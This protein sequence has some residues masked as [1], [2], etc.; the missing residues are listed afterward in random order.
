MSHITLKSIGPNVPL[1]F[2]TDVGG[3]VVA[4]GNKI[5]VTG[6]PGVTTDGLLNVIEISVVATVPLDYSLLFLYGGM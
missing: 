4:I 2:I 3:P 5:V 6:G 1:E